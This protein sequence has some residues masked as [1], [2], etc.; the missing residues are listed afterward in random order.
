MGEQD[1]RGSGSVVDRRSVLSVIASGTA[2][3]GV[4]RRVGAV[5]QT[6]RVP[7][8][9]SG[10]DVVEWMKVPEQWYRHR[11]RATD[12]LRRFNRDHIGRHAGLLTTALTRSDRTYGD[13]NGFEIKVNYNISEGQ[14]STP[15]QFFGIPVKH[16]G[17]DE[18]P[19]QQVCNRS[20]FSNYSGG[21][22]ANDFLNAE[23]DGTSGYRVT[24]D[25]GNEYM[26]SAAH[27]FGD[28]EIQ[29]LDAVYQQS[30]S[31]GFISDGNYKKDF[32][33]FDNSDSNTEFKNSIREPDGTTRPIA[34][35][36]DKN[37]ISRRVT[38]LFDG[39]TRVGVGSGKSTGGLGEMNLTVDK[40]CED[41]DGFGIR[42]DTTAVAGDSGGPYYSIEN[43]DAF[44]LGH[45]S[46]G[47][48]FSSQ[49]DVCGERVEGK[50]ESIGLPCYW[51]QDNT[52]YSISGN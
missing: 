51:V 18:P 17:Q 11:D 35:F 30:E 14:P 46:I 50:T 52:K 12:I 37:E 19:V 39:H 8:Y 44:L 42:G 29:S 3:S 5:S 22:S 2:L 6:K 15:S 23:A 40:F 33:V 13:M 31:I 36:A 26:V 49:M 9:R 16:E 28:C 24:D 41:L 1:T 47:D 25:N 34:G 45:H 7:K 32:V 48:G 43:G 20:N 21:T 10:D 27:V 38:D 4:P